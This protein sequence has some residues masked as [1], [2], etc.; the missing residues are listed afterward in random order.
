MEML[1]THATALEAYRSYGLRSRF[2]RRAICADSIPSCAPPSDRVEQIGRRLASFGVGFEPIE[3]LI[4]DVRARSRTKAVRTRICS[5]ELP[6]GSCVA[7]GGGVACVSP[8]H[9][10]VQMAPALTRLELQVLLCELM[11]TYSIA[12]DAPGGM[13]QRGRALMT[14]ESLLRHLEMLGRFDGTDL[15]RRAL[16]ATVEGLASPMETKVYLRAT[17]SPR[18]G[19]YGIE[20]D[21]VNQAIEVAV[22]GKKGARRTR[23]PD[24]IIKS[25]PGSACRAR[26]VAL[27]YNGSGHLTRE[28]QAADERRTN[29]ILAHGG[30]EYLLNK[31]LY[32]DLAYTDELMGAICA[33]AGRRSY[34]VTKELAAR[35]RAL[36]KSLWQE[37]ERIDGV[38]W[39]GKKRG[40]YRERVSEGTFGAFEAVPLEAYGL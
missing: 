17:L 9:L 16:P 31:D 18:Y 35:R 27:E 34:R 32:D 14:K 37:L 30:V 4:S 1:I 26:F 8:E 10:A 3:L 25:R 15:V 22:L 36:R 11:G 21:A 29:E 39:G 5:S 13:L 6:V 20:I 33:D 23:K 7:L 12:P 24:F 28:Q 2:E 38:S 40:D 19:G